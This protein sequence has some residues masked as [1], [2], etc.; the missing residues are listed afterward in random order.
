VALQ[1]ARLV[2]QRWRLARMLRTAVPADD[3]LTAAVA[4]M[5]GTMR[6]ARRPAVLL[7]ELEGAA[8]VCGI[9]RPTLV[10]TRELVAT[11][12]PL[13]LRLGLAH[14]LAHVKRRDLA[15]GWLT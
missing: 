10:L 13:E 9:L 7:T 2:V 8:F 3:R 1:L 6:L 11:L 14:E 15:W 5:A 12:S 4:E